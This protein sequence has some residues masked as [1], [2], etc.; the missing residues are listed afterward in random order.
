MNKKG[1]DIS[2]NFIIL[3]VL[4]LIALILIALFFTGGLTSLFQ[5]TED[6]GEIS[7][8][9]LSLY[10]VNCESYCQ[11]GDEHNWNNPAFPSELK[12]EAGIESCEEL[13]DEYF[14]PKTFT[15]DCKS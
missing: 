6:V 13:F 9:K 11:L 14:E 4:A 2:L 10:K 8:Q 3:A 12:E 15:T 5:Q 1:M 7:T